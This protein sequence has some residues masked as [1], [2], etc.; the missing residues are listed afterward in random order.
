MPG[1]RAVA[2]D[3]SPA[4]PGG[5]P[6]PPGARR[7]G[8]PRLR[9]RQGGRGANGRSG[10]SRAR[11]ALRHADADGRGGAD[12]RAATSRPS[13]R[14]RR[15]AA[16][17]PDY[18][19]WVGTSPRRKRGVWPRSWTW[20]ARRRSSR[21]SDSVAPRT[22]RSAQLRPACRRTRGRHLSAPG[23]RSPR[24]C[25]LS[26]Q[27][28]RRCLARS[29]PGGHARVGR[30]DVRRSRRHVAAPQRAATHRPARH[31]WP[32]RARAFKELAHGSL[33]R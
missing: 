20:R 23:W 33:A 3:V 2:R 9:H 28:P 18:H 11:N 21:G 27:R 12:R 32:V 8:P 22:S 30:H 17:L 4:D 10:A 26:S 14:R 19:L 6:Y 31:I 29:R 24:D 5:L 15:T 1:P 16:V 7:R 25:R 13:H